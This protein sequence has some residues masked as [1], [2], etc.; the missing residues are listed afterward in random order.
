MRKALQPPG[1]HHR[2]VDQDRAVVLASTQRDELGID[3]GEAAP[4]DPSPVRGVTA[5]GEPFIHSI[6]HKVI[7]QGAM[8]GPKP[9]PIANGVWLIASLIVKRPILNGTETCSVRLLGQVTNG[10][11]HESAVRLKGRAAKLPGGLLLGSCAE[12]SRA[13][14]PHLSHALT[15]LSMRSFRQREHRVPWNECALVGS[16]GRRRNRKDVPNVV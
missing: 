16:Y 1:R 13:V 9:R 3:D 14:Y 2:I 4:N 15:S 11:G 12:E 8:R 5:T 6:L 10:T 7:Y